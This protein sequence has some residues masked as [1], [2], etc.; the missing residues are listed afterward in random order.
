MRSGARPASSAV[1]RSSFLRPCYTVVLVLMIMT[2]ACIFY[3][4]V[5]TGLQR[6][7]HPGEQATL[8]DLSPLNAPRVLNEAAHAVADRLRGK[9]PTCKCDKGGSG[10]GGGEEEAAGGSSSDP[11]AWL[12]TVADDYP[13][14]VP[15]HFAM[16]NGFEPF[17]Q[18]N[19]KVWDLHVI[20]TDDWYD[21]AKKAT[22]RCDLELHGKIQ[23]AENGL[24]DK[25]VWVSALFDLK[26]G[27]AKMGEFQRPM[28]EYYRRFQI[29]LDRGFQMLIYIPQVRPGRPCP[30]REARPPPPH[31][32]SPPLRPPPPS[33]FPRARAH[34][35]GV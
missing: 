35:T 32:L 4:Y 27:E 26:R 28:D 12:D 7:A 1:K 30:S 9:C 24:D 19:Q 13:K 15:S 22:D 25:V 2:T 6:V 23:G 21:R 3:V 5:F 29:V 17:E 34:M 31:P 10:G 18:P 16:V 33:R 8:K 14:I 11:D 20:P